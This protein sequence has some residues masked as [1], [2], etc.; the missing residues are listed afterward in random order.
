MQC[1]TQLLDLILN[2]QFLKIFFL[3]TSVTFVNLCIFGCCKLGSLFLQNN[4]DH[5]SRPPPFLALSLSKQINVKINIFRFYALFTISNLSSYPTFCA[6][7]LMV[8]LLF[9]NLT[10]RATSE[11]YA[12]NLNQM[13]WF[14]YEEKKRK[15]VRCKLYKI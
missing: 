4:T 15:F 12:N 10:T 14:L 13:I 8:K 7:L 5:S 11:H 2:I 9:F 1:A 6:K 3:T